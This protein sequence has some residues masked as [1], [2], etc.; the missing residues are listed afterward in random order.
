MKKINHLE[1]WLSVIR[2]LKGERKFTP[3]CLFLHISGSQSYLYIK[4]LWGAL[5][6]YD[7]FDLNPWYSNR[8]TL[9]EI[10]LCQF[11]LNP[12]SWFLIA[13][14]IGT[15]SWVYYVYQSYCTWKQFLSKCLTTW[16]TCFKQNRENN[17]NNNK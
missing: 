1:Y 3:S 4:I 14:I 2:L 5:N 7:I 11:V 6:T 10:W 9:G 8:N 13:I 17:N 12:T 16:F 15:T